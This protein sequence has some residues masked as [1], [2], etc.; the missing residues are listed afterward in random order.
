MKKFLDVVYGI[1]G[2]RGPS[3]LFAKPTAGARRLWMFV[4]TQSGKL[5]VVAL[6]LSGSIG[7]V[8]I[9]MPIY[10]IFFTLVGVAGSALAFGVIARS[11]DVQLDAR[12]PP[13]FTAGQRANLHF[14]LRNNGLLSAFNVSSA[15]P[16]ASPSIDFGV[17]APLAVLRRGESKQVEIAVKPR[18]RGLFGPLRFRVYSTFPFN[19]IL[20]AAVSGLQA[21]SSSIR[22]STP[23]SR[24]TCPLAGVFNPAELPS[25]PTRGNRPNTQVIAS[26]GMATPSAESIFA[27]GRAWPLPQWRISGGVFLSCGAGSRHLYRAPAQGPAR[28]PPR[29][30]SRY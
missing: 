27:R 16:N 29:T 15:V 17:I 11:R 6:F 20:V 23:Y 28:R 2:L 22:P 10:H 14:T 1:V 4:L 5:L 25:H 12:I 7:S 24:L 26:T 21:P 3:P 9:S 13:N 18:R 19:L 8:S 30:R